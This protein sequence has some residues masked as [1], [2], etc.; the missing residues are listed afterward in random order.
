MTNYQPHNNGETFP[1]C[2]YSIGVL[3]THIYTEINCLSLTE[4]RAHCK[5]IIYWDNNQEGMT[6]ASYRAS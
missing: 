1:K 6:K 2:W 3:H 4:P 5:Y